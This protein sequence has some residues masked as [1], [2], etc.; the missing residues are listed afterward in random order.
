MCSS[1]LPVIPGTLE[2]WYTPAFH[3]AHP[4]TIDATAAM[5]RGAN[6]TAYAA[7][8]AAIRAADFRAS[9]AAIAV[10]ALVLAGTSDPVTTPKDG[11]YLADN[12]PDA[13]YVELAAAHLSNV[14]APAAFNA[15]LLDFLRA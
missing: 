14:E 4:E 8:C 9:L 13:S 11:R 6:V 15:A 1:D 7:C 2:R 12:I 5:L 3:A 10:P